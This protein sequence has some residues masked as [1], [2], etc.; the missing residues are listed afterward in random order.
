MREFQKLTPIQPFN[1]IS[2]YYAHAEGYKIDRAYSQHFKTQFSKPHFF[3]HRLNQD[4]P[5]RGAHSAI[6]VNKIY[7]DKTYFDKNKIK[8]PQSVTPSKTS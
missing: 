6:M 4:D 5:S 8:I 2:N 3:L 7:T 1:V